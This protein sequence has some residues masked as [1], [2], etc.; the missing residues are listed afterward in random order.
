M[1]LRGREEELGGGEQERVYPVMGVDTLGADHEKV[2]SLSLATARKSSRPS[3]KIL[4]HI[5][6]LQFNNF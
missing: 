1:K 5:H 3:G 6:I 2:T 4:L